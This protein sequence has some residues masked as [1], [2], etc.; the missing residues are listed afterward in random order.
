VG[1]AAFLGHSRG[2]FLGGIDG[3][4]SGLG[5]GCTADKPPPAAGQSS[6]QDDFNKASEAEQ[7]DNCAVALP[8]FARLAGD[9]RVKPGSLAAGAVAVWRGNC[10]IATGQIEDGVTSIQAG[11]PILEKAGADF[12]R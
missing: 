5:A 6:L 12:A 8:I 9:P 3:H 2:A 4:R 1:H 7:A 11:L 10:L